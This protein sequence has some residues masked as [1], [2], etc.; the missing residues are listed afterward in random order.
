MERAP[1]ARNTY[2]FKRLKGK[3][4]LRG[5]GDTAWEEDQ[6]GTSGVIGYMITPAT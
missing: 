1:E 5:L 4:H 3:A 6:G 2:A